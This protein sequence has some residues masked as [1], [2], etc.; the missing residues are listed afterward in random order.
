MPGLLGHAVD[1]VRDLV[2]LDQARGIV[3]AEGI[4]RVAAFE[5]AEAQLRQDSV[6]KLEARMERV[7]HDVGDAEVH[8]RIGVLAVARA[9]EDRQVGEV[10]AHGPRRGKRALDV[11]D[12][13]HE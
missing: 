10:L 1:I 3:L 2:L 4:D 5:V 12:R 11:L 8:Q 13:E 7:T 6:G 9:G